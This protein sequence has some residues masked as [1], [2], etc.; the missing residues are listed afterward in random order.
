MIKKSRRMK[1]EGHRA[2]KG[3]MEMHT[4]CWSEN[5]KG[6]RGHSEDRCKWEDNFLMDIREIG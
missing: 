3:K 2:H 5:L 4:K 1:W 6:R